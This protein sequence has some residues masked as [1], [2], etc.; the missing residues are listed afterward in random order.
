MGSSTGRIGR[1]PSLNTKYV[2]FDRLRLIVLGWKWRECGAS[3]IFNQLGGSMEE[4]FG[5]RE[6]ISRLC[7]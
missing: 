5:S 4:G 2:P 1:L 3:G 6:S 7:R